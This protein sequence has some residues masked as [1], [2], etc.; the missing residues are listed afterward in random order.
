MD[1]EIRCASAT[2]R[3]AFVVEFSEALEGLV[4]KYHDEF[5]LGGT[6]APPDRRPS[7]E[8]RAPRPRSTAPPRPG[9]PN[10]KE[11]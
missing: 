3:G 2:D 7:P 1:A 10:P 5:V 9:T 4:A 8:N 6:Q 11:S